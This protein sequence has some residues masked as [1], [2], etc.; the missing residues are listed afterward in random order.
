MKQHPSIHLDRRAQPRHKTELPFTPKA[1]SLV[2]AAW[3]SCALAQQTPALPEI[4]VRG[5]RQAPIPRPASVA[6]PAADHARGASSDVLES[7]HDIPGAYTYQ[8]GGLSRLPVIRGL[9]DERLRL[10][11]DG[12]DLY[13][14][15]PNHM[16]TPLSYL[17]ASQ[18][19]RVQTWAGI[20]PVSAGGDAIGGVVAVET[21]APQF[22]AA[23][24]TDTRGELGASIRSN[25]RAWGWHLGAE[26]ASERWQ[27]G[28]RLAIADANNYRAGGV[29]KDYD[30]T[31]RAGRTLPRDEVGSSAYRT[32]NHVLS[33]ALREGAHL[34]E[35]KVY[36]QEMPY[37][38]YPNQRMDLLDNESLKINLR[39]Q[40]RTDWGR[41]Q[42]SLWRETVDHLMDFGPDKRYWYG[43]ASG[44]G[45]SLNGQPCSPLGPTCAA[46]MPMRTDS[47]TTGAKVQAEWPVADESTV[48][49]GAEF[50]RFR[51]NDYWP[52]SGGGMWPGTFW[53][54]RDGQRDR[55]AVYAEYQWTPATHWTTQVGWR[56]ERVRTDAGPVVGYNPSGGG[57][58]GADAAAFNARNRERH[59]VNHDVVLNA[60]YAPQP[61]FEMEL[62]LA[63]RER[64]PGLY[65]LYPWSTWQMAALM[66]NTVGDGN[67]Y[68]GN[69]DLRK[70]RAH[71]ASMST[72][73]HAQDRSWSFEISPHLTHVQDFID[74][75]RLPGQPNTNHRFVLLRYNNVSARLYGVD[76]SGQA[77]LAR[78]EYGQWGIRGQ[79]SYLKGRNRSTGDGLY[80]IMPPHARISL[81]HRAG[82]WDSAI[83]LVAVQAKTQISQV[84]NEVRTPGY[85]LLNVRTAVRLGSG[86]LE[87]GIDNLLDRLYYWPT[88]GAYVGQGTTMTNPMPPNRP[89]WGTAVPGPGRTFW[90]AYSHKF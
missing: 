51:L 40:G 76:V 29:F 22:A 70:E 39:Y 16:N 50:H 88:G 71:T 80:Q 58:Q 31:G 49:A 61:T 81:T 54:I 2:L 17:L 36:A 89:Q 75:A 52:P 69:P 63:H 21:P 28:Y 79:L 47:H 72:R 32:V 24:Q 73:W 46:G 14:A 20:A 3:T 11:I 84:R 55:T 83:E 4:Q 33:A 53:N 9:A 56:V 86:K 8:A 12:M 41:L 65:E 27:L 13:A 7:M 78:N 60:R 37:Q 59:F 77:T 38:L 43:M 10:Q 64:A 67:G 15:C 45:S 1:I 35:A 23:G 19:E 44:G 26:H 82:T 6:G 18:V 90:L 66:N 62:G 74:A 5:D 42:A 87:L 30:F 48:R 85:G 57:N 34:W 25:G 68:V